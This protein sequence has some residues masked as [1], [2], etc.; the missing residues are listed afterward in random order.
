MNVR[1]LG[2]RWRVPAALAALLVL[3]QGAGLRSA[4][5]YRRRAIRHG[6]LWRVLTGNGVHLGWDHLARNLAGLCLIWALFGR[7][8]DEREWLAVIGVS[9]LAVGLGLFAFS[10]AITW[11]VGISGAL[12][13]MFAAGA[14]GQW[15]KRPI[16]A[17]TLLLGM[18]AVILWTRLAGALPEETVD[19]GGRVIP[20]AHLYGAIGGAGAL[21]LCRCRRARSA[22]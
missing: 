5:E 1:E 22:G 9:S 20:Q 3:L 13:G 17:G 4:L 15:P 7:S 2:V 11:Y 12:F 21:A 8:L 10:P 6:E 14:L 16:Y 19:L 18:L